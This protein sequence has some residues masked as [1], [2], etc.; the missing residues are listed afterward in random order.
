MWTREAFP[1]RAYQSLG[2]LAP[3]TDRA[4][5]GPGE[6]YGIPEGICV[7]DPEIVT[8]TLKRWE[9]IGVTGVNFL[10]NGLEVVPQAQVLESMRLF[11]REVMPKFRSAASSGTRA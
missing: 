5:G 7:G 4:S 3:K 6:A 10:L 8:A 11:A 2:N 9:A 1:T